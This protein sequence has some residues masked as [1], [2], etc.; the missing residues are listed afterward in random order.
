MRVET[1][2]KSHVGDVGVSIY[3]SILGLL[4]LTVL[5]NTIIKYRRCRSWN[6]LSSQCHL[7]E[8]I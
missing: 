1:I 8:G 5:L 4:C 2:I 7:E 6:T 3:K